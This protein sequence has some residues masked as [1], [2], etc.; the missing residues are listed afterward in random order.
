MDLN[1][2]GQTALITGGGEGM[3]AIAALML[4]GDGANVVVADKDAAK[5]EQVAAK[6]R[7]SGVR[8]LSF[9]VDVTDQDAV[10]KMV[11]EVLAQLGG[12]DM[13]IHTPGR[14]ERKPL[15]ASEKKD[16]DFS[17]GL[18]LYGP[19]YVTKAVMGSMMERGGG[20]ITYVVSEAGRVGEANNPVYSAAKGG[21]VALAKALAR[22]L[23]SYNIRVNCVSLSAMRTPGGLAYME[24]I[25]K[26]T[27]LPLD[28]LEKKA[29]AKYPL[30]RLGEPQDA[31]NA[32]CFLASPR[33]SWITG[34]TLGVNGGYAMV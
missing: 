26:S 34:Q 17:V 2:K 22:E 25:A 15:K 30:R 5:A 8:G 20:S 6:V 29:L 16:W 21:V 32:L 12:V 19:L 10:E 31:A 9:A 28:E 3:G 7:D 18:N 24:Q 14:G 23:G 4:A 33:A 1:V 13:L 27:G 11:G